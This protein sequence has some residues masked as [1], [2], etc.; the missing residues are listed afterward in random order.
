MWLP[1]TNSCFSYAYVPTEVLFGSFSDLLHHFLQL[2]IPCTVF[3]PCLLFI[4]TH[5]TQ[6]FSLLCLN[7][8]V[9]E[10]PRVCF[11]CEWFVLALA[12]AHGVFSLLMLRYF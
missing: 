7:I 5:R 8:A 9:A 10:V 2:L 4:Q 1:V 12:L 3:Q 11:C 6:L